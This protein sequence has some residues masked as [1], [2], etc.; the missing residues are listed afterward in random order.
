MEKVKPALPKSLHKK[1][2]SLAKKE[3]TSINQLVSTALAEKIS[4]LAT[5]EYIEER[6][7]KASKSKFNKAMKKVADIEAEEKDR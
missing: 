3:N 2:R 5:E 4:A 7:R 6:A 1:A